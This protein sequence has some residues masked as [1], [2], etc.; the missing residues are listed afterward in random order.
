MTFLPKNSRQRPIARALRALMLNVAVY[1][2]L[3]TL[4]I[5]LPVSAQV[6]SDERSYAI[7]AG[8]LEAAIAQ[9]SAVSGVTVSFAPAIVKERQT[10]GLAGRYTVEQGLNALLAGTGL[11]AV[12]SGPGGYVLREIPEDA[13]VSLSPVKVTAAESSATALVPVYA[14]GQ[15]AR[16]GRIGLLGNRDVMDTPFNATS[17]TSELVTN[18]QA[19]TI[20]D[21]LANDPSVRVD[22][23][24]LTSGASVGDHFLV[25][26]FEV[27]GQDVS[28]DGIYGIAPVRMFPV[29]T[30]ERV[31]LLKGPN[32]LL[33][34]IAPSG[35]L[36]GAINVVPKRAESQ[37]ITRLTVSGASDALFGG[38]VDVGRRFGEEARWGV[39]VNGIYRDGDTA[40]EDQSSEL[41]VGVVAVDYVGDR[42]R[43]TLDAGYQKVHIDSPTP[44]FYFDSGFPLPSSPDTG[45]R[46]SQ[47]WEYAKYTSDYLLAKVEYDITQDWAI[48][49]AAGSSNNDT[50]ALQA[51]LYP[52][53]QQ[54]D[55]TSAVYFFPF[56]ED[57]KT[58]QTG[59]RGRLQT[60]SVSHDINVN[61]STL[62][63]ERGYDGQY[64]GFTSFDTSIYAP[65]SVA[66][67]STAGFSSHP[68]KWQELR[69]PTYAVSDTLTFAEGL[70]AL[71][72]GARHQ[73]VEVDQFDSTGARIPAY[74]ESETTPAVAFVYRLGDTTSV[75]A[76]YIEGLSQGPT[77]PPGT[78]NENEVFPPI[79]TKQIEA[80]IKLDFGGL[81]TTVSLFQIERPNGLSVEDVATG[82]RTYKLDGEQRNRGVEFNLFGEITQDIRL[83]GG[84]A[85]TD[86]R[87]TQTEDGVNDGN[88]AVGVPK[89]QI[90]LGGEW[91]V[92][93]VPGMTL[94]VRGLYTDSQY[95]NTANSRSIPS[96]ARWDIGARY[97]MNAFEHPLV[98]RAGVENVADSNYWA[99]AVDG[100]LTIG[101]PRTLRLSATVDF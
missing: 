53:D 8:P 35:S 38:H 83:L 59:V 29:E 18:Q 84:A 22:G 76:N 16:G 26:G 12:A 51:D 20:G 75:Y 79:K 28:V 65:A 11:Q 19:V 49:A 56:T 57:R 1:S 36:G 3:P 58:A 21:V 42:L 67:P 87:L 7:A 34:G 77:A 70:F 89:W 10:S 17:F 47:D 81:L 25:R 61:Y 40:I 32:A 48:Y 4:F 44:T 71:T 6:A 55:V 2:P 9:F 41:N 46:V 45:E 93:A 66:K 63:Q 39:R 27:R 78:T 85:Y 92:S 69:T 31:E 50:V 52:I 14:G 43:A 64:Y 68:P 80:G 15:V 86:A 82:L 98:L 73:T 33:N 91:D 101:A 88:R 94:S 37:P 74:D 97:A 13:A 99:S 95:E 60:G 30:A 24:S 54:G 100:G 96:W 72:L 23:N 5:A 90:N 62:E